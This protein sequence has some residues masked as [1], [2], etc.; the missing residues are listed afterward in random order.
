LSPL[1]ADIGEAIA[2]FC[3][4]IGYKK[5]GS[6]RHIHHIYNGVVATYGRFGGRS[7]KTTCQKYPLW[8]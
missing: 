7:L 6:S 3:I 2:P 8:I 4:R 1:S 5:T